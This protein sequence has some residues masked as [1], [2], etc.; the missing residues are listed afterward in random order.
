M[1]EEIIIGVMT[2]LVASAW[3]NVLSELLNSHVVYALLITIA[4]Y[5]IYQ[6]KILYVL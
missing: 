2:S 1:K 3:G 6:K 4:C 5:I